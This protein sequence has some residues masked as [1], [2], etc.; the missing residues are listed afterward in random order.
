MSSVPYTIEHVTLSTIQ[1]M[2]SAGIFV[3]QGTDS[4]RPVGRDAVLLRDSTRDRDSDQKNGERNISLPGIIITYLGSGYPSEA[5]QNCDDDGKHDLVI[6]L[7]DDIPPSI[8]SNRRRSYYYWL[9]RIRKKLQENPY[10]TEL[11]SSVADIFLIQMSQISPASDIG[12]AL[13]HQMRAGLKVTA[14][15]REPRT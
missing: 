7:V 14:Y 10:R 6:Q 2:A 4:V 8:N 13:H 15:A 3:S 12:F 5:G 9:S 1:D 11:H